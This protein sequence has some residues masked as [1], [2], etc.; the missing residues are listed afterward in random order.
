MSTCRI[1][2]ISWRIGD[3]VYI[4]SHPTKHY[5]EIKHALE[6]ENMCSVNLHV[7]LTL[8]E[9]KELFAL[10]EKKNLIL[11]KPSKP[12]IPMPIIA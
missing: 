10:A 9:T 1:I 2:T 5:R 6:K 8:E 11:M 3:C 12:L 4:L 7:A